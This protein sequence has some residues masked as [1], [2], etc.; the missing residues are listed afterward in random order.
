VNIQPHC[1]QNPV[2]ISHTVP[3]VTPTELGCVTSVGTKHGW[4]ATVLMFMVIGLCCLGELGIVL[5][6]FLGDEIIVC[7]IGTLICLGGGC[8]GVL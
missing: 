8:H 6:P 5:N 7:L 2:P 1:M 3:A 4:L